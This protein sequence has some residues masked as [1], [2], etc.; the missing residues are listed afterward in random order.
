MTEP[1]KSTG[2]PSSYY[3]F[4]PGWVTFNDFMDHQSKER[5][6]SHSFHLGNIC[7]AACRWGSKEGTSQA[8]DARK[9]VYSGLRILMMIEGKEGVVRYLEE[10][11][12]DRQFKV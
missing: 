8:Y 9:I 10:L 5:W 7:K 11:S 3:D 4:D 12:N 6:G 1:L 2:G